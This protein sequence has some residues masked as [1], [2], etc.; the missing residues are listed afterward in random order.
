[1]G[2]PRNSKSTMDSPSTQPHLKTL[3]L[4]WS[5]TKK[6]PHQNTQ[7]RKAKLKTAEIASQ[8]GMANRYC[9]K[10]SSYLNLLKIQHY[11]S[12]YSYNWYSFPYRVFSFTLSLSRC[13]YNR[14]SFQYKVFSFTLSLLRSRRKLDE[15]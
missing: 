12:R 5:F 13:S 3:Q 6:L 14:S 7:K 4:R 8:Q 2:Y 10:S 9:K 11:V 1:M 15:K